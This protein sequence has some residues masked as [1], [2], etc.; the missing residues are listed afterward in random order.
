MEKEDYMRIC[1]D[2]AKKCK[3]SQDVPI[4]AIIVKDGNIISKAHNMREKLNDTCS[5]AEIIA[6]HR[7]N[8]KLRSSRLDGLELYVTK[9][10]CLMCMGAILSAKIKKVYFG[11]E[12]KRFGTKDLATNN[13]FNHKCEIE[14]EI[15]KEECENIL[16][17][18]F[19]GLR[20][21]E[22]IRKN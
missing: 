8:K 1:I 7:A 17:D 15:L 16:T 22:S 3:K 12:D 4:G 19:R 14:G 9:E 6:I 5:H 21:N 18:F 11:V 13:N 10:P 20:N 2:E